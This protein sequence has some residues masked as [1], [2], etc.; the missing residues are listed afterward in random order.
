[1]ENANREG[2]GQWRDLPDYGHA[3]ADDYSAIELPILN[4]M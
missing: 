3:L 1:M 2:H 4:L